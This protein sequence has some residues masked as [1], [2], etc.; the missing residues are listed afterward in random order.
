MAEGLNLDLDGP[1]GWGFMADTPEA[2]SYMLEAAKAA[3]IDFEDGASLAQLYYWEMASYV[4]YQAMADLLKTHKKMP[5]AEIIKWA[6]GR[7]MGHNAIAMDVQAQRENE[8]PG[9]DL[10]RNPPARLGPSNWSSEPH[11]KQAVPAA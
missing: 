5:K 8:A 3:E 1:R 9:Q 6:V 2:R 7:A 4:A 10:R 11:P